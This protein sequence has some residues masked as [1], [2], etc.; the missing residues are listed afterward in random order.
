MAELDGVEVRQVPPDALLAS[1]SGLDPHISPEYAAQQVD[2]VAEA[3]GTRP[4]RS[5]DLVDEHTEGRDARLPR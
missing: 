1:G 5:R 4:E 3:R 2:R